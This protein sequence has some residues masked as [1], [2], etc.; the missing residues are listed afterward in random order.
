MAKLTVCLPHIEDTAIRQRFFLFFKG[1]CSDGEKSV[2]S[3]SKLFWCKRWLSSVWVYCLNIECQR[4]PVIHPQQIYLL[5]HSNVGHGLLRGAHQDSAHTTSLLAGPS[6][7][8][9]GRETFFST[10]YP[11]TSAS[12]YTEYKTV[13]QVVLSFSW[14][15]W[16]RS[17][18]TDTTL[19]KCSASIS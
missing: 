5:S 4:S 16:H 18:A 1:L 3:S 12:A 19:W 15:H 2:P 8:I 10:R 17:F 13:E 7:L 11:V 14:I 6:S 9:Y